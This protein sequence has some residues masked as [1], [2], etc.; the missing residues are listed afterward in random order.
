METWVTHRWSD[1]HLFKVPTMILVC[2]IKKNEFFFLFLKKEDKEMETDKWRWWIFYQFEALSKFL[3]KK[4]KKSMKIVRNEKIF[5]SVNKFLFLVLLR[6]SSWMTKTFFSCSARHYHGKRGIDERRN[7]EVDSLLF[8]RFFA[9]TIFEQFLF[10]F[11]S[12]LLCFVI[13]FMCKF[14]A[15][16]SSRGIFNAMATCLWFSRWESRKEMISLIP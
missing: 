6:A 2:R 16:R 7:R 13:H 14:F 11:F 4:M 1:F 9:W 10:F 3:K 5:G 15:S 8:M 12:V